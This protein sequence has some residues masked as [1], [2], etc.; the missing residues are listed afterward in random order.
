VTTSRLEAWRCEG[1]I[2]LSSGSSDLTTYH[3]RAAAA[4]AKEEKARDMNDSGAALE[5]KEMVLGRCR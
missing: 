1:D 4:A 2:S 3:R 5:G